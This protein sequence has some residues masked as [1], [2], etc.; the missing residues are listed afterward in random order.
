MFLVNQAV[1][2]VVDR[3]SQTDWRYPRNAATQ[4][5]PREFN[6][7]EKKQHLESQALGNFMSK[8]V[9]RYAVFSE[10]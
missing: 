10:L 9:S 3:C 7:E 8:S 4:Y 5:T 2:I 1:P 6:E